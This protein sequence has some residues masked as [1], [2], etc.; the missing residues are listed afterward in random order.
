MCV[1]LWLLRKC[2]VLVVIA[3]MCCHVHAID[4]MMLAIMLAS[5]Y[6]AIVVITCC[7]VPAILAFM[8]L[9]CAC[10]RNCHVAV[11]HLS[12]IEAIVV[13]AVVAIT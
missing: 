12:A 3:I 5:I 4:T 2:H 6:T 7:H 1:L 10:Y 8:K 13:P 9:L 11:V